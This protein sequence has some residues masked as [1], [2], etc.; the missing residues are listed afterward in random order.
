[1][2]TATQQAHGE[3]CQSCRRVR[4]E[5]SKHWQE[6]PELLHSHLKLTYTHC[7]GCRKGTFVPRV[8]YPSDWANL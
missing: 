7:D 4:L 5:G 1:M 2:P 6:R 3:V 8:G